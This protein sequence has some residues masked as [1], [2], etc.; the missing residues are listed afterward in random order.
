MSRRQTGKRISLTERDFKIL[1]LLSRYRFLRSTHLHV[2]AGGKSHKRFVERLGDLYHEGGYINR[3]PQQWQAINARYMPAVYELGK[4]GK[5]VLAQYGADH[6]T[7]SALAQSPARGSGR[8]YHHELMICDILS[9]IEIGV[10]ADQAL[11]HVSWPEILASPKMPKATLHSARP[12]AAK[13]SIQYAKPRTPK[14]YRTEG[15]LV[16]D[17]IFGLEYTAGGNKQ[18]RF[19]ALEADRNTE[20]VVRGDLRQSSYIR[21]ILQYREIAARSIYK[22]Q[23]GLPNLLVLNVT[24]NDRHK[25]NIMDLVDQLTGDKGS[26]SLLFKTMPS[27][28][29]LEKA[30]LPA[31]DILTDAW[32]RAGHPD[33]FIDR[34]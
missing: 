9:S 14:A 13:V 18:Y 6:E 21:K 4:A 20:P 15:Q 30:P 26:T 16:P 11:R 2:L 25:Q 27:L 5:K 23:W 31:P 1:R 33:F 29:S 24:T 28:A 3:P 32:H 17:A 12:M 22:T 10:R 19:F 7:G 8:Q 34:P